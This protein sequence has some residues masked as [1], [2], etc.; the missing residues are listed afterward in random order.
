LE[1]VLLIPLPVVGAVQVLLV[2]MLRAVWVVVAALGLPI[3]LLEQVFCTAWV[4]VV[5]LML[6]LAA[7]HRRMVVL[8]EALSL[9]L[10]L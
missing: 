1:E 5:V 6:V 2:E 8:E 10:T 7:Q 3:P 9:V 4:V